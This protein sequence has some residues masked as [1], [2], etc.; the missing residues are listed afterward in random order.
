MQTSIALDATVGHATNVPFSVG[1]TPVS[2]GSYVADAAPE[3]VVSFD[4]SAT[5]GQWT[6][7][8]VVGIPSSYSTGKGEGNNPVLQISYDGGNVW[9]F[10]QGT[11]PGGSPGYSPD[12]STDTWGAAI[13]ALDFP[14]LPVINAKNSQFGGGGQRDIILVVVVFLIVLVLAVAGTAFVLRRRST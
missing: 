1:L 4:A 11:F 6:T 10:L 9:F 8:N 13:Y 3:N 7:L 5:S 2:S 14:G 12:P